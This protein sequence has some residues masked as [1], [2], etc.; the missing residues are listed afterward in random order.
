MPD[1]IP[2]PPFSDQ[3]I[4]IIGGPNAPSNPPSMTDIMNAMHDSWTLLN[5]NGMSRIS[6][7]ICVL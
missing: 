6:L 5:V 7:L 3:A 4:A 2:L 1:A